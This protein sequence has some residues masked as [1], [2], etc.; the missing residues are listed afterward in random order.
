MDLS[1]QIDY[2]IFSSNCEHL[3]T[4]V[5]TGVS[6]SSQ[7]EHVA[8]KLLKFS[9]SSV[10]NHL[11][12]CA[13]HGPRDVAIHSGAHHAAG[14]K[15]RLALR[16]PQIKSALAAGGITL[17]IS[18]C[19]EIPL[20]IRSLYK[21]YRKKKFHAISSVEYKRCLIQEIFG[22]IG[23]LLGSIGG[24]IIGQLIVPIPFVG[25]IVGGVVGVVIG[26]LLGS[27]LGWLVS[28]AVRGKR[29]VSLPTVMCKEA[30]TVD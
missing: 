22:S 15:L 14:M 11:S 28:R 13:S 30:L 19:V 20:L 17:A 3:I 5:I 6:F 26:Q 23:V 10:R 12:K 2:N 4:G 21:L 1:L 8:F 18:L 7:V 27:L 24:A 16:L 29:P 25:T 9:R